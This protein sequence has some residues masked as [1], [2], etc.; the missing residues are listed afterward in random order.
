MFLGW[1]DCL[2]K[3][4]SQNKNVKYLHD[5]V[6]HTKWITSEYQWCSDNTK[7][8]FCEGLPPKSTQSQHPTPTQHQMY[9]EGAIIPHL[10]SR[11]LI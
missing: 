5:M 11:E 6:D 8:G 2:S 9:T 3:Q 10:K 1:D 4:H 7:L